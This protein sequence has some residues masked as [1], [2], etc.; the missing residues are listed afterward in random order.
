[1]KI[2]GT[3][4]KIMSVAFVI[5]MSACQLF[6]DDWWNPTSKTDA[7]SVWRY[8]IPVVLKAP[9]GVDYN[10]YP[11]EI[12]VDF[13]EALKN[14]G[15]IS[16]KAALPDS[17]RLIAPDG[18]EVPCQF[19]DTVFI[20]KEDAI[21]NGVGTLVFVVDRLEKG[22][23]KKYQLYF[24]LEGGK[25]KKPEYAN[26][27]VARNNNS[28]TIDT[29]KIVALLDFGGGR[30][31]NGIKSLTVKAA[32][33][34]IKIP[35]YGFGVDSLGFKQP[36]EA[37][38]EQGPVFARFI[39]TMQANNQDGGV[40]T[41]EEVGGNEKQLWKEIRTIKA[42]FTFFNRSAV[43]YLEER[44]WSDTGSVCSNFMNPGLFKTVQD[45]TMDKAQNLEEIL[46]SKQGVVTTSGRYG[47]ATSES[48]YSLA[49]CLEG[50]DGS[51]PRKTSFKWGRMS[52]SYL[53]L[54]FAVV[55]D[56]GIIIK[57]NLAKGGLEIARMLDEAPAII[58]DTKRAEK[59]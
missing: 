46:A 49:T 21:G 29:G 12:G 56:G 58:C 8:R 6:A 50:K 24:D 17:I 5:A 1:M 33:G 45:N 36:F 15:V 14:L 41:L 3:G 37:V 11:V 25:M 38:I 53:L 10:D 59:K 4:I 20:R 28:A 18:K 39:L 57:H 7:G 2:K 22:T 34:D 47:V 35:I 19:E 16:E 51:A 55:G 32:E 44:N 26:I 52:N 43:W 9:E 40:K 23:T 13:N 54:P 30:Y 42:V 31:R 27:S 48:G